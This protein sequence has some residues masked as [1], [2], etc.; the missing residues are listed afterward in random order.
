MRTAGKFAF[1]GVAAAASAIYLS[2]PASADPSVP[3]PCG[4]LGFVCNMVPMMPELDHDIDLTKQ[5][6][7][8]TLDVENQV[9]ADVCALSCV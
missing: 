3:P 8:G 5:Y 6:P 1:L 7:Q 2:A 9:P 4:P